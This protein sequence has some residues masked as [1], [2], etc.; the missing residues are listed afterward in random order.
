MLRTPGFHRVTLVSGH[1]PTT[2]RFYRDILGF[3][4]LPPGPEAGPSAPDLTFGMGG[5]QPGTLLAFL[6]RPGMP[7][8]RPGIGG[9]HHIALGT[10]D[11]ATLLMWKRWLNQ[12]GV[13]TS[14]PINRGYFRSL[15]FTDPDGQIL[16][17]ATAGPGYAIDEPADAL[18]RNL[19]AHH[20]HLLQQTSDG[21]DYAARTH[22][23]PIPAVLAP[24][25]ISG[26]HHVSAITSDTE[27]ADLF[28]SKEL[29]LTRVK[30]TV[31]Q[32]DLRMPHH[33]WASYDGHRVAPHSSWTLFEYPARFHRSIEGT[34]QTHSV[35]FRASA[36]ELGQWREE[37]LEA[38]T[39]VEE[40]DGQSLSFADPDGIKLEL[41]A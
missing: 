40:G 32:D 21:S 1:A 12:H 4:L 37:L 35:G 28:Y 16:E 5:G 13:A 18:G 8:G 11:E 9:V 38:G 34:G 3:E 29:G 26:I 10:A 23:E 2:I 36:E 33:F 30:K 6:E 7:R 25:A 15:Y 24:M 19:I 17:L 27:R 20:E 22:P 39:P 14:G 31:N 41:V